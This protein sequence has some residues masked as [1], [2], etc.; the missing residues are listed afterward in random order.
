MHQ[1][2]HL[3]VEGKETILEPV[4]FWCLPQVLVIE[5]KNEDG[6]WPRGSG[7]TAPK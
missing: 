4:S 7:S 6:T 3:K 1:Y 2:R 5:Q